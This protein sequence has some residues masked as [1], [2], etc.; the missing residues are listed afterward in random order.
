M[1]LR[2]LIKQYL[3]FGWLI[4]FPARVYCLRQRCLPILLGK[5]AKGRRRDM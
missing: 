3:I 1:H 2:S 4:K 5:G